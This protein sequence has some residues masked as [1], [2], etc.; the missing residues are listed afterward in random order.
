M[1][2]PERLNINYRRCKVIRQGAIP[3]KII[4]VNQLVNVNKVNIMS[5]NGDQQASEFCR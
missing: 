5:L 4:N 3:L 1:F 2:I